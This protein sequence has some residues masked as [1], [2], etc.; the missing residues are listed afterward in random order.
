MIGRPSPHFGHLPIAVTLC[1]LTLIIGLKRGGGCPLRGR[2][3]AQFGPSP[4]TRC[5]SAYLE[6]REGRPEPAHV[7]LM[8]TYQVILRHLAKFRDG[9]R[10]SLELIREHAPGLDAAVDSVVAPEGVG[11]ARRCRR[12]PWSCG[13]T[14]TWVRWTGPLLEINKLN[15]DHKR[16]AELPPEIR[17]QIVLKEGTIHD[18]VAA[19]LHF[20]AAAIEKPRSTGSTPSSERGSARII[21]LARVIG[22]DADHKEHL[23]FLEGWAS[24]EHT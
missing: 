5:R 23:D 12:A 21:R 7:E 4:V 19:E 15:P 17:E 8:L 24:H 9:A 1:R 14:G 3:R 11:P 20:W 10:T 16:K 13:S 18:I 6:P 2:Q 22:V